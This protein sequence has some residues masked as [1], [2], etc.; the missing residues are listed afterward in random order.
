[1][2]DYANYLDDA[3][4]GLVADL[5]K[6][7]ASDASMCAEWLVAAFDG[8]SSLDAA[9]VVQMALAGDLG[10]DLRNKLQAMFSKEVSE[11]AAVT[12]NNECELSA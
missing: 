3:H 9:K 4:R 10:L 6:P 8:S 1:M 11:R 7:D 5:A 2:K 12:E